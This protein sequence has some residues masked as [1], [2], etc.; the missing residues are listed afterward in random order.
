LDF[1]NELLDD[2]KNRTYINDELNDRNKTV[3]DVVRH[4]REWHLMM[5]NWYEAGMSGK[6][7]QFPRKMLRGKHYPY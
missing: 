3:S 2:I 5:E 4:L 1:I 6:S 7:R